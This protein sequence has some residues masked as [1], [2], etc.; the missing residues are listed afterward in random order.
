MPDLTLND[1]SVEA[2][3]AGDGFVEFADTIGL[4]RVKTKEI[5][6]EAQSP[7]VLQRLKERLGAKPVTLGQFPLTKVTPKYAQCICEK[8]YDTEL[9]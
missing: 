9:D 5:E 8:N 2:I 7:M 4:R 1:G 3:E 6:I